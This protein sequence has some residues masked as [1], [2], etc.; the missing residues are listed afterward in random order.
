MAHAMSEPCTA[1]AHADAHPRSWPQWPRRCRARTLGQHAAPPRRQPLRRHWG[2]RRH[3]PGRRR[4][5]RSLHLR[6]R[7]ARAS[8]SGRGAQAP[9]PILTRARAASRR[10]RARMASAPSTTATKQHALLPHPMSLTDPAVVHYTGARKL[11]GSSLAPAPLADSQ[12]RY[13]LICRAGACLSRVSPQQLPLARLQRTRALRAPRCARARPPQPRL[14][15]DPHLSP[16]PRRRPRQRRRARPRRARAPRP[17]PRHRRPQP[18]PRRPLLPVL[19]LRP[20]RP[21]C[22]WRRRRRCWPPRPAGRRLEPRPRRLS[23]RM[24]RLSPHMRRA[25]PFGTY[26]GT[27]SLVRTAACTCQL[28]CSNRSEMG[29]ITIVLG[30][31]SQQ[32]P[33]MVAA[34]MQDSAQ[35]SFQAARSEQGARRGRPRP[36]LQPRRRRPRPRRRAGARGARRGRPR[37]P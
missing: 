11:D 6:I 36:A 9:L 4:G 32:C 35:V 25:F 14:L 7:R 13:S 8:S 28:S 20:P 12:E 24:R 37:G 19:P 26:R 21:R 16:P 3:A 34:S 18:P 10:P 31:H 1:T 23:R 22:C 27:I 33:N 29:S 15:L 5:A 30:S 2:A 17:P